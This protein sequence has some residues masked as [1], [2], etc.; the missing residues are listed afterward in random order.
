VKSAR[1]TSAASISRAC[2]DRLR[3]GQSPRLAHVDGCMR[4][5][6]PKGLMV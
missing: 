5:K 6:A 4:N 3:T 1:T 2:I